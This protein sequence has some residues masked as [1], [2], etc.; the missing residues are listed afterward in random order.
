MRGILIKEKHSGVLAR[1]FGRAITIALATEIITS[2][3]YRN[4]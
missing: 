2:H 3:N 1:H 4:M